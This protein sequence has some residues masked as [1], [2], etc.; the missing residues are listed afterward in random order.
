MAPPP[1]QPSHPSPPITPWGFTDDRGHRV[2]ADRPPQRLVAYVQAAATLEDLGV[3][4]HGVFGS[5]HDGDAPDPATSASLPAERL[6]WYG[7]GE[8]FRVEELL[9]A[10]P[11]LLVTVTY[12][13]KSLYALPPAVTGRIEERIPCLALSVAPGREVDAVRARF[14]ELATGLGATGEPGLAELAAARERVRRAAA[15][16]RARVLALSSAG[17]GTVHLARPEAWPE[18]RA[19]AAL[20][21]RLPAPPQGPGANWATTAWPEATALHPDVVL[22]DARAHAAPA[23]QLTGPPG[24]RM[25]AAVLPWNPEPP[26]SAPAHARFLDTVAAALEAHAAAAGRTR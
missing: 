19:L 9:A 4:V 14:R 10:G 8:G 12:D 1:A 23:A 26:A 6:T 18:L 25:A 11:D 5:L 16:S 15:G 2:T 17:P 7:A 13:E 22:A 24:T 3:R 20:G 21:V